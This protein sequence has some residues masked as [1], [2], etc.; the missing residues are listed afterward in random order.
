MASDNK[1]LGRFILDGIAPAPRGTPQIEVS[2]DLDANGILTVRAKDKGA[3]KEQSIRIEGS[4]ALTES[5][6]ER[7]KKD[8]EAHAEEDKKKREL[9]DARNLAEQAVLTTEKS[10]KDF[11]DKVPETLRSA[12]N[13]K[14]EALKKVKDGSDVA[15]IRAATDALSTELQ[16]IGEHVA[17]QEGNTGTTDAETPRDTEAREKDGDTDED[18]KQS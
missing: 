3:G 17:K 12:I 1:S 15:G 4:S 2:F 9:V 5:E 14:L 13:E 8:A 18:N 16:K 6:I 10:L 11:G 7:M